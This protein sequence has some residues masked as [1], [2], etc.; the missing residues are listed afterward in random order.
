MS[1]SLTSQAFQNNETIPA[2]YTCD[3]I[4]VNPPL[5]ISGAPE[6]TKSFVLI[7]DDPDA[8][9]GD[10]VHWMLWNIPAPTTEILENSIPLGAKVAMNDFKELGYGG[11]CPQ[12]GKHQYQ[13]K[14]YALDVELDVDPETVESKQDLEIYMGTH[15]IDMA[16]L[17]GY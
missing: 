15:I 11:P 5:E 13:F 7:V 9:A 2:K 8:A 4:N 12:K 6:N 17:N 16:L 3:G 10:W 14:L 1:L